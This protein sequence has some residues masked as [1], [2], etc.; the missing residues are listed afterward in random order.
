MAKP[1]NMTPEQEAEWKAKNNARA[2]AYRDANRDEIRARKKAFREANRE[3][4]AAIAKAYRDA[5]REG[6]RAYNNAWYAANREKL[7]TRREANRD[8]ILTIAK[9]RYEANR[10]KFN[11]KSK[12]WRI[13]NPEKISAIAK[14]RTARLTDGYV[15]SALKS[16]LTECPP[17]L[18]EMKREQLLMHRITKQL[19]ESLGEMK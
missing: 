2:K 9:D 15:A 1:K 13:A 17:E 4:I 3:R 7:K 5:N 16:N 10:E 19:N 12:A 6:L 14:G 11:A 8:K 18:I